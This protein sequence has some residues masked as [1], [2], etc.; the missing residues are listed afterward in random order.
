[1]EP[2]VSGEG[3]S[4]ELERAGVGSRTVAGAI[5]L[6]VQLVALLI[7]A[8]ADAL[9]AGGD[10]AMVAA[11]LIA[12][13]VAIGVGYPTIFEWLSRGRTLGKLAIG[14]RVVRDDGGPIGFRQALIRGLS[15]FLLEKPGL[16]APFGTALGMGLLAFSASSKRVGDLMAGTFVVL[17]R[18]PGA[19]SMRPLQG[20][21]GYPVPYHLQ[22]WA[23]SLDLS[24]LDDQTA[25][26]IRQF[27]HRAGGMNP[28]AAGQLGEQ[29][30]TRVL[31]VI[32]PAPPPYVPTPV[33]LQTVLAERRRRSE[34]GL[35]PVVAAQYPMP[36]AAQARPVP[37][38][39]Q[40][41]P[42]APP[43]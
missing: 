7:V 12:E 18:T 15:G 25:F 3:V 9:L 41:S 14:L 40:R 23:R 4:L 22:G 26:G 28:P 16:I 30:R 20:A 37:S 43:S 19:A 13:L 35:K 1:M 39:E 31:A 5:D 36:N 8:F 38:Q 21:V 29:F 11:L 24:R 2:M 32:A 33:L 10:D 6:A 17:E 34:A 27:L 42:F